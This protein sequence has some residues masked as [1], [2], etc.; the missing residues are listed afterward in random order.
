MKVEYDPETL[1]VSLTPESEDERRGVLKII[2][3]FSRGGRIIA[4]PKEQRPLIL[5]RRPAA[6]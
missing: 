6:S 1:R 3:V 2:Q 4:A 5:T